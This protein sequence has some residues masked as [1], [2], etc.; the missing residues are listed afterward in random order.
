MKKLY[1]LLGISLLVLSSNIAL[2]EEIKNRTEKIGKV[3]GI[4]DSK[5]LEFLTVN[6]KLFAMGGLNISKNLGFSSKSPLPVN[7]VRSSY[8]F[9]THFYLDKEYSADEA[10]QFNL[11]YGDSKVELLGV[12]Q[13]SNRLCSF[14]EFKVLLTKDELI[15]E[16][17]QTNQKIEEGKNVFIGNATVIARRIHSYSITTGEIIESKQ[18]SKKELR[19]WGSTCRTVRVNSMPS[20]DEKN[21]RNVKV[22]LYNV[23]T[24]NGQCIADSIQF[25]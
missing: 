4:I 3:E 13:H 17:N 9:C 20:I 15:E 14:K 21:T 11:T 23:H 12:E 8:K 25:K 19:A 16:Q 10:I 22:T 2:S 24:S 6:K 18:L 5:Y 7:L 1:Q